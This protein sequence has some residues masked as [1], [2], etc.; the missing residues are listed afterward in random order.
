[1]RKYVLFV[2][3]M[4]HLLIEI[5]SEDKGTTVIRQENVDVQS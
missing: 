4:V 3:F 5:V 2:T 1:M